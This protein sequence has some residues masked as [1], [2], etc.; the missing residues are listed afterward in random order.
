MAIEV[1]KSQAENEAARAE[2]RRRNID[3]TSSFFLRI[4]RK[5]GLVKG[6][7]VGD[8]LKSWDVLSTIRFIQRH[9]S[10]VDPILDI[11][12]YA[13][14]VL[15]ALHR[16]GYINLTGVDLNP[17]LRYMPYADKITYV[18]S[19]FMQTPFK[20][21]S[22]SA[23][24]AISVIEHGFQR[25]KLLKELARIIRPGGYFIASIDYWSEKIDT[26]GIKVFGMDWKIFSADDLKTLVKDA[27]KFDFEPC[28][29][30]NFET[31]ARIARWQGKNYTFAWLAIKKKR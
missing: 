28:G 27:E 16:V 9:L 26:S 25:K 3:C 12:A 14:E 17:A 6:I 15:C 24:T 29:E 31:F 11:G 20:D 5:I 1:L 10:S 19:D 30:L 21:A 23:V 18:Q 7:N 2:M 8:R 4:A 13:S 22:F